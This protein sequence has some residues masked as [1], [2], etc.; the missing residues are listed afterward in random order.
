MIETQKEKSLAY[1][2]SNI[3]AAVSSY[4]ICSIGLVF[5]NKHLLSSPD[6]EVFLIFSGNIFL[7]CIS[8]DF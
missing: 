8:I 4:W 1:Q 6:I 5:I 3:F 7:N 2:Y